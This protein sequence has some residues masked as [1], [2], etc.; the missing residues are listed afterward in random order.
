MS[1]SINIKLHNTGTNLVAFA[2]VTV[3]IGSF[4]SIYNE[5]K[6]W[7][8]GDNKPMRVEFPYSTKWT[9]RQGKTRKNY[10]YSFNKA[11]YVHMVNIILDAYFAKES[12]DIEDFEA[13]ART[14]APPEDLV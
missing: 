4:T 10:I 5:I 7:D 13:E 8:N 9:D 6:I 11:T 1:H 14:M 3:T 2:D 12:K